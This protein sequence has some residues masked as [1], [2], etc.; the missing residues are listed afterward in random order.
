MSLTYDA[1]LEFNGDLKYTFSIDSSVLA[2]KYTLTGGTNISIKIG[3]AVSSLVSGLTLSKKDNNTLSFILETPIQLKKNT[4]T[5]TYSYRF[6]FSD[7]GASLIW[8]NNTQDI[9]ALPAEA[10]T[11]PPAAPAAGGGS[12]S[13]IVINTKLW[14]TTLTEGDYT[15]VINSDGT[16][17]KITNKSSSKVSTWNQSNPKWNNLVTNLV[18]LYK[19]QKP[20]ADNKEEPKADKKK[21][22]IDISKMGKAEIQWHLEDQLR[23]T[24]HTIEILVAHFRKNSAD[25]VELTAALTNMGYDAATLERLEPVQ[26][27]SSQY[28]TS[29]I[30]GKS[31]ITRGKNISV[32]LPLL[33]IGKENKL[34][35]FN[36]NAYIKFD[37]QHQSIR[38][39]DIITLDPG[40]RG[41]FI[42]PI[43]KTTTGS[44]LYDNFLVQDVE[45]KIEGHFKSYSAEV[46]N[47]FTISVEATPVIEPK[48]THKSFFNKKK[49]LSPITKIEA[50]NT[51]D[52]EPVKDALER[53]FVGI[54]GDSPFTFPYMINYDMIEKLNRLTQY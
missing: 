21:E 17:V 24:T 5:N 18:A 1:I 14:N 41:A 54:G 33:Y 22:E 53:A 25:E 13:A 19:N 2:K 40:S 7:D 12:K 4:N 49:G 28:A 23:T 6:T 45:I 11:P 27:L 32:T 47:K 35:S 31:G 3:A 15:F 36:D 8:I 46:F 42:V 38:D 26:S 37:K 34:I 29:G 43:K 44:Q 50:E 52:Y 30:E 20:E 48:A 16:S 51:G 9:G 10:P 39:I